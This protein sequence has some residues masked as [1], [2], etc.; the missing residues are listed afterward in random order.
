MNGKLKLMLL[1]D[2]QMISAD[3]QPFRVYSADCNTLK[4]STSASAS[5]TYRPIHCTRADFRHLL[6]PTRLAHKRCVHLFLVCIHVV[7]SNG[8]H[9]FYAAPNTRWYLRRCV[10]QCVSVCVCVC[11][12]SMLQSNESVAALRVHMKYLCTFSFSPFPLLSSSSCSSSSS[13]LRCFFP[14]EIMHHFIRH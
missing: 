6:A 12:M 13:L 2:R 14:K 10:C 4:S 1:L 8:R 11:S 7:V 5:S 3:A 9:F